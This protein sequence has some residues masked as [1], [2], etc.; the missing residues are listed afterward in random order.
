MRFFAF[1][2][3]WEFQMSTQTMAMLDLE[4]ALIT[5]EQD[6]KSDLSQVEK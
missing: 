6:A 5:L 3:F 2:L 4:E 1:V